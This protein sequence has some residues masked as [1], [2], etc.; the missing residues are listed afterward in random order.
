MKLRLVDDW[1]RAHHW[2]STWLISVMGL[3]PVVYEN[4]GF[5]Q[6]YVSPTLFHNTMGILGVLTLAARMVKQG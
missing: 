3:V 6:D 2:F 4:I 5:V 1:K